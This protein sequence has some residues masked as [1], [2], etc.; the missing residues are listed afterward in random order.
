MEGIKS[1]RPAWIN[2]I[3]RQFAQDIKFGKD[4]TLNMKK[5]YKAMESGQIPLDELAIILVLQN[6]QMIMKQIRC[7][8]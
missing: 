3:E 2:K 8:E 1:D 4:P 7:K 5:E 6:I